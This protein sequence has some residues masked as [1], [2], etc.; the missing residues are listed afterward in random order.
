MTERKV[1]QV[2]SLIGV[3]A[4][5]VGFKYIKDAVMILQ[6]DKENVKWTTLYLEIGRKYGKSMQQ[7]ERG[8]RYALQTARSHTEKRDDIEHYI[9]FEGSNNSSSIS[10]L[11]KIIRGETEDDGCE[12]PVVTEK[13]V[14]EIVRETI[15]EMLGVKA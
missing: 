2:L 1:E 7:V 3:P 8:I 14:R 4:N 6:R 9:G 13:R 12:T 10:L 15:R 11:Y 5:L